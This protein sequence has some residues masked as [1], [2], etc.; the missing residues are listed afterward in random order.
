MAQTSHRWR[1]DGVR[2]IRADELDANTPQTPG[3][4][5]RAAVTTARTGAGNLWAG[6]V[7]IEPKARTGAHHH[8]D[9]ES[10]IYVV[11]GL[12]RMRWGERLEYV[13]EAE[14]GDFIYV[15]PYVPHQEINA[16]DDL[17]LRCVLARNGQ[18]GLV[19]NLEIEAVDTPQLIRWIDDLHR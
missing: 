4:Q 9:L 1:S 12:A 10:V 3:M 18:Q 13:A 11:S 16:S 8:G 17:E 14:A 7:T 6:T 2:I 19:V 15:P 5:R